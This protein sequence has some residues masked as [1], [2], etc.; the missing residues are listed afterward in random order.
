MNATIRYSLHIKR[1]IESHTRMATAQFN[2]KDR[3]LNAA[4]ALFATHGF[5]ATSLR[6]VTSQ[7]QVNIAAVN[8]HFGSK[9]NLINEVFRRRMDDMSANRIARLEAALAEGKDNLEGILD[10]FISPALEL[11]GTTGTAFIRILARA[12]VEENEGLREYISKRY[13]HV[14]RDF[15][16]ALH[17]C[18]PNLSKQELYWRLDFVAGALTYA[19]AD[20]GLI[21]RPPGRSEQ[22]HRQEASRHLIAFAIAGLKAP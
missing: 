17:E 12:Y 15:A 13:G 22:A 3:I 9:E 11:A 1:L 18:L 5:M 16:H 20:F 8:Y 19:M 4:E 2:T 14:L 6:E 10:A 7:A 21:R